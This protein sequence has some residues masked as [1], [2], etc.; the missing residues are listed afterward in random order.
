M[1]EGMQVSFDS[2]SPDTN[3]NLE[4]MLAVEQQI[5]AMATDRDHD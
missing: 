4:A 1:Y 2:M 5:A 3:I